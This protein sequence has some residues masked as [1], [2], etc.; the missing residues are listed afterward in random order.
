MILNLKK[1]KAARKKR[2]VIKD[3]RISAD[4][5]IYKVI[6]ARDILHRKISIVQATL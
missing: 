2:L 4:R 5:A 1:R 6:R 3:N